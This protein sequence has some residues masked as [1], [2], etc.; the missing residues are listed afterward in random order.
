MREIKWKIKKSGF[1][2]INS[3]QI[4]AKDIRRFIELAKRTKSGDRNETAYNKHYVVSQ[5]IGHKIFT[6]FGEK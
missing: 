1:R 3:L 5:K 2:W 6:D 4:G